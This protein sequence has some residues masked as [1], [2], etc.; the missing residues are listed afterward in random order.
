[1]GFKKLLS[2][3]QQEIFYT[4]Y[5]KFLFKA[6]LSNRKYHFNDFYS[7]LI[8]KY[9][10]FKNFKEKEL[11]NKII[12]LRRVEGNDVW[13][14]L[15][16]I[17]N[18]ISPDARGFLEKSHQAALLAVE[19]YNKPLIAYKS[20]G[21]IVM[22]M[23][24]WTSLFHAIFV[25][26]GES[27]KYDDDNYFDLRKCIKK[28]IGS[29][30]SEIEANLS[31]LI[32]I[33]DQITHRENPLIDEK[34]FGYCQA[35]LN[36]Y[37]MVLQEQFGES[38]NLPNTLAYS[39]QF[40][41]KYLPDQLEALKDYKNKYNYKILDFIKEYENRLFKNDPDIFKSQSYCYRIYILPKLVKEKSAE[42]AVEFINYDTLDSDATENIDKAILMIKENRVSGN[43]FKASEVCKIV[44]EKLKHIKGDNW[45]FTASSHHSKAAKYFKIREGYK[46]DHP[47]KTKKEYCLYDP[48]FEQ[49][50]YTKHWIDFLVKQLKD[51]NIYLK[52]R[53][54]A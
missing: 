25:S 38:Y 4:E 30:K 21:F 15:N 11:S 42:A 18:Y 41:K 33:R 20:E 40:S 12:A 27:I 50:I 29:L 24:A 28:Y 31:L 7:T 43:Y 47:E 48:I 14:N 52:I 26:N 35:C 22:M 49:Y 45:K 46:T 44:R 17:E 5:H 37:Q 3:D 54:T 23:I 10:D 32:E 1:M 39:L 36:N 2:S 13:P 6:K 51:D 16:D 53:K 34:L 8:G 9:P 19:I